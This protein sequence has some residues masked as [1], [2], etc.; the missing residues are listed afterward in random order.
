M[1]LRSLFLFSACAAFAADQPQ[2]GSAWTRNMVSA[3]KNLPAKFDIKTGENI[4]WRAA[5]GTETHSTPVV[6]GGRVVIGTNNGKPRDAKHDGDRGVV[7][8]FDEKT[9]DFVWQLVVPK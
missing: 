2:W 4:K 5:I 6:S 3:E 1:L 9:G 7:M 8:C